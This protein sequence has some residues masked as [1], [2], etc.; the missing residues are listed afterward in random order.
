LALALSSRALDDPDGWPI[1][2]EAREVSMRVVSSAEMREV[3]VQSRH[4]GVPEAQLMATAGAAVAAATQRLAPVG[5][6]VVLVG[7]GNNGSDALVA[8]SHLLATGRS[9]ALWQ[10]VAR[11]MPSPVPAA[12]LAH[13]TRLVDLAAL[14]A[15]LND[16]AIVVDGLFGIGLSRP[17]NGDAAEAIRLVNAEASRR[18]LGRSNQRLQVLAIDLPSG[19]MADTGHTPEATIVATHTL[20]LGLPK[21]GLYRADGPRVAG[22]I[23]VVDIGLP[24]GIRVTDGPKVIESSAVAALLP[25]RAA[26]ADKYVAGAVVIVGGAIAYPGAPRL[27]AL[28]AM[29]SG[30]GYVTLAVPRSIYGIVAGSMLE[31]TFVPL[32]ESDGELGAAAAEALG[33]EFGRFRA[34]VIGPGLGREKGTEA[35]VERLLGVGG[36]RRGTLGFGLAAATDGPAAVLPADL[37]LVLDADALTLMGQIDGW[38]DRLV[39][40]A[41]LTPNRREMARLTGKEANEIEA[42]AWQVAAE[43]AVAWKQVVVL[44]GAPTVGAA[45]DGRLWTAAQ[46]QPALATAGSGDVLSGVIGGLLAQGLTPVDAAVVGVQLGLLAAD[47]GSRELGVNGLMAGDLPRLVAMALRELS[48]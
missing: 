34:A 24:E 7:A 9:V 36:R 20:A 45:P 37:P 3:E 38:H 35:F 13:A 48:E 8:A 42:Q 12:D 30:A 26:N 43:A 44:K 39:Q 29:R 32:P 11:T 33:K 14:A 1:E 5:L 15:A 21:W 23:E 22:R 47:H 27:A 31:A 10:V 25:R 40:P 46:A 16:A 2:L 41:V 6:V 18:S 19:M 17:A 28:G 4:L